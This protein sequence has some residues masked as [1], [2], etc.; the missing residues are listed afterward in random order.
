MFIIYY[1]HIY[2]SLYYLSS[3]FLGNAAIAAFSDS[4]PQSHVYHSNHFKELKTS[5]TEYALLTSQV[6]SCAN[7]ARLIVT[8]FSTKGAS[9]SIC[10]DSHCVSQ[11]RS[12]GNLSVIVSA[13]RPFRLH[14]LASTK[15]EIKSSFDYSEQYRNILPSDRRRHPFRY[16]YLGSEKF[17]KNSRVAS[18]LPPFILI[19]KIQTNGGFCR[20][21]T[22]TELSCKILS[23]D[24]K[25]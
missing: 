23:C 17:G 15:Q 14:I 25:G 5:T 12:Y 16:R 2:I 18:S 11:K 3:W 7:N 22:L 20:L 4:N 1:I 6:V 19:K 24:F 8:Y 9:L 21:E 10:A 13:Q